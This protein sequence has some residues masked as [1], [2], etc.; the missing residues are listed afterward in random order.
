MEREKM[1][2]RL[3]KTGIHI[4]EGKMYKSKMVRAA[5]HIIEHKQNSFAIKELK[6]TPIEQNKI[7]QNRIETSG[8]SGEET[9]MG[10]PLSDIS[11]ML[12]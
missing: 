3:E 4:E 9:T 11:L 2:N 8:L 12:R 5:E 1:K 6:Q 7:E 10:F